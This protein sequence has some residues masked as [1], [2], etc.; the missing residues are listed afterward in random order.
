[1]P[2]YHHEYAKKHK[3]GLGWQFLIANY[4]DIEVIRKSIGFYDLDPRVDADR[5]QHAG[6]VRIGHDAYNRWMMAPALGSLETV[7]QVIKHA[8]I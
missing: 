7:M 6:V 8:N 2:D 3:T 4:A 5:T 1:M